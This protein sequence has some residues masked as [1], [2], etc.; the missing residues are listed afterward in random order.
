MKVTFSIHF[1]TVWGQTLHIIGSAPELGGWD[2]SHA[3]EMHYT[4]DGNWSLSIDLPNQPISLEYRY[5]L[6]SNRKQI[7]EE[8]QKKSSSRV[9]R[10]FPFL[11]VDRLLASPSAKSG[12]LFFG[13]YQ[14]SFRA[15]LRQV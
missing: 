10:H 8:W 2:T 14:K 13:L 4:G 15:S 9:K 1:H 5:F 7:F 11:F 6:S 12:I 3:C